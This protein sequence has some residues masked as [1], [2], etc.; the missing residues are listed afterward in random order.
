MYCYKGPSNSPAAA[1]EYAPGRIHVTSLASLTATCAVQSDHASAAGMSRV[2][3][4]LPC[5]V[6]CD[7]MIGPFTSHRYAPYLEAGPRTNVLDLY[8]LVYLVDH[9]Q[10]RHTSSVTCHKH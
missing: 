1:S 5:R 3:K 6:M 4:I 10:E 9:V 8:L 2:P 7:I